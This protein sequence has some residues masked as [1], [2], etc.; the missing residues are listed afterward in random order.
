M[1]AQPNAL[2]SAGP[3]YTVL[4][5][6]S[7]LI[8]LASRVAARAPSGRVLFVGNGISVY[9]T[10]S[11]NSYITAQCTEYSR[12]PIAVL[13]ASPV[14]SCPPRPCPARAAGPGRWAGLRPALRCLTECDAG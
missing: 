4:L 6:S 9:C 11:L 2:L 12:D 7:M 10:Y 3:G 5:D 1:R 14:R 8:R 13:L